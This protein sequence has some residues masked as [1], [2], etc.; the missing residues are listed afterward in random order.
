MITVT[1]FNVSSDLMMLCIPLPMIIKT[2]LPLRRKLVLSAVFS[3]GVFTVLVAILNRY[4]NFTIDNSYIFL[5]WYNGEICTAIMIA[6]I[7]FCWTLLRKVF[8]LDSWG[9]SS[10]RREI[11]GDSNMPPTVG[12]IRLGPGRD[13]LQRNGGA[14]TLWTERNGSTDGFADQD[15]RGSSEHQLAILDAVEVDSRRTE[16][17]SSHTGTRE[18]FGK[19]F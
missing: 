3:L 2:R 6:N 18:G 4:F 19:D 8:H 1:V 15:K 10:A 13:T 11:V 9:G 7:P 17:A 14:T 16:T 12:E 5:T